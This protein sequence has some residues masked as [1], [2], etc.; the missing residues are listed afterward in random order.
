[1]LKMKASKTDASEDASRPLTMKERAREARHAAY[2]FAKER[3]KSDP[4]TLELK[5]K[6]KQARRE[7]NAQAKERRKTDPKEIALRAKLKA[8]RQEA[9][10]VAKDQRKARAGETKKN[11]R[12]SGHARRHAIRAPARSLAAREGVD[13]SILPPGAASAS[14]GG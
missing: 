11:E 7:A 8:N 4:R 9:N 2:V 12:A 10:R 13:E 6:L 3:R 1:M 5:E 14:K